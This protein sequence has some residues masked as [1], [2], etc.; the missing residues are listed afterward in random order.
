M[1]YGTIC[2]RSYICSCDYP[3]IFVFQTAQSCEV[4]LYLFV[5]LFLR[6]AVMQTAWRERSPAAR[7]KGAHDALEKNADCAPAYILLA[8]EEAT[9]IAE[10]EKLL[11][12]A[13][14]SAETNYRYSQQNQHLGTHMEVQHRRDTNVLIYIKRRLA[15]CARK[16]GKLKEAVKMFRDVSRSLPLTNL[17]LNYIYSGIFCS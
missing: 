14:K 8:E 6:F 12:Q 3:T 7:V 1:L 9:T 2:K 4:D 15:M 10:A 17:Q 11:R 16:L 13:L 5:I